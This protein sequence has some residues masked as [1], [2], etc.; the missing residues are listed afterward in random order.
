MKYKHERWPELVGKQFH[1]KND[2][3][4]KGSF[5]WQMMKDYGVKFYKLPP[6][7]AAKYQAAAAAAFPKWIDAV[8][9]TGEKRNAVVAFLKTALV[10][11]EKLTGKSFWYKP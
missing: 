6:Q 1:A 3:G 11:R 2:P 4:V 8:V 9:K 10:E 7:E 5:A